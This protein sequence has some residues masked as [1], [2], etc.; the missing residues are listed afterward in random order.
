MAKQIRIDTGSGN[1]LL[2]GIIGPLPEPLLTYRQ[3]GL[4]AFTWWHFHIKCEYPLYD[5]EI[6]RFKIIASSSRYQRVI[7]YIR[8]MSEQIWMTAHAL[9]NNARLCYKIQMKNT[10]HIRNAI[11]NPI[12]FNRYVIL[13]DIRTSHM[14]TQHNS[15]HLYSTM[16]SIGL[17]SYFYDHTYQTILYAPCFICIKK[18]FPMLELTSLYL[19]SKPNISI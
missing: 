11:S 3:W 2:P 12:I 14:M 17:L 13:V 7:E 6:Y 19:I 15:L 10:Q 16:Q 5:F 1:G 8:W 9:Y 18:Q 4:V